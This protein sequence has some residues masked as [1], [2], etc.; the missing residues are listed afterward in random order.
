M[1]AKRKVTYEDQDEF[2]T[3]KI[4]KVKP[5][6]LPVEKRQ[7]PI[8]Q[9]DDEPPSEQGARKRGKFRIPKSLLRLSGGAVGAAIGFGDEAMQD[10]F[11]WW[12]Y[13]PGNEVPEGGPGRWFR[14]MYGPFYYS[15]PYQNSKPLGRA[16]ANWHEPITS[17]A[18]SGWLETM[19]IPNTDAYQYPN[20]FGLWRR[21]NSTV[22][23][24]AHHSSWR[25]W[26]GVSLDVADN[27]QF[28]SSLD[29]NFPNPNKQRNRPSPKPRPSPKNQ[30]KPQPAIQSWTDVPMP[31][32]V[33]R[34]SPRP[35]PAI[36]PSGL[37]PPPID[38]DPDLE[39]DTRKKPKEEP[40][41]K[42]A[43]PPPTV[44][45]EYPDLPP[46]P[47]YSRAPPTARVR[48]KKA[49]TT[50]KQVGIAVA[51]ALDHISEGAEMVDALYQSLPEDVR[52]RWEK[53]RDMD[54]G[55]ADQAGQYGIDGADWKAKAIWYNAHKIDASSAFRNIIL[56][57]IED[58]LYGMAFA[59]R[60]NLLG[61]GRKRGTPPRKKGR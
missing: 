4:R 36:P 57:L 21:N 55:M 37:E 51:R 17:Q 40:K 23:R 25:E 20:Q 45:S 26:T 38:D 7:A 46:L 41:P 14:K 8:P 15:S 5:S 16:T 53:G 34:Q 48:E 9:N 11:N 56:N 60:S 39:V 19:T 44:R 43:E 33:P 42:P 35:R 18:I 3:P 13:K 49:L 30:P 6:K 2:G 27:V 1:A 59:A 28:G 24:Y 32:P 47:A 54:R 61:R 50:S 10:P 22:I 31:Q 12:H 29:A 52:R 58:E